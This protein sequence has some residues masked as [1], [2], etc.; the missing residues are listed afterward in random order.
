ML[1]KKKISALTGLAAGFFGGLF[2]S[3]G[4]TVAVPAMEKFL[5]TD[6]HKAHATAIALILPLCVLSGAIYFYGETVPAKQ[7]LFACAGG[8][9]G[10]HIGAK[11]L[12][13]IKG[14]T[15]HIIFGIFMLAGGVRMIF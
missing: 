14:R 10:G 8:I 3:G 5:S 12:G 2:G 11:L 9:L 1:S 4:G 15:L 7:T 6:E 13:W